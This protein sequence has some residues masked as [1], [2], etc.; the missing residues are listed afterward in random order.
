MAG[1]ADGGKERGV[2]L[3][4][5]TGRMGGRKVEVMRDGGA[6]TC[7]VRHSLVQDHEFTGRS[8]RLKTIDG[9]ELMAPEAALHVDTPYYKGHLTALALEKP[10]FDLVIGNIAGATNG[11]SESVCTQ[12]NA[13]DVDSC[14]ESVEEHEVMAQAADPKIGAAVSTRS[15]SATR[16]RVE[17][18]LAVISVQDLTD[19]RE[20]RELVGVDPTLANVRRRLL[21]GESTNLKNGATATY[22]KEHGLIYRV[23]VKDSGEERRQLV[24]PEK[25]REAVMKLAHSTTLSGHLGRGKTLTRVEAHFFW[26]GVGSDIARFVKSCDI[27]Q[28]TV[29]RGRIKPAPLQP[30]PIIDQPF[31]KMAVDI[32]GPIEPRASDGSRYILT[33][34][35][36]A[37]RWPEAVPLKNVETT[38]VAEAMVS[39][40]CRVGVPKQVLS[41]RGTQ[42]TSGMMDEVLRLL[43]CKGLHTTPYHPM[44]N[45]LCERFNGTLK[46]MLKRMT[47]EQPKEWPRFIA[48]LLFAYREAP[49]SSTRFSPFEMVYGR[50]VRGPLQMLR[51]LWDNQLPDPEVKATYQYVVD[52][53]GRLKETCELA[54]QELLK[55]REVQKAYYDKK[56]KLRKFCEGD[57]CLVLLPTATNKLLAQWKGPFDIQKKVND[58]NYIVRINGQPK[59]FHINMLKQYFEPRTVAACIETRVYDEEKTR[60]LALVKAQ[61]SAEAN[62]EQVAAAVVIAESEEGDGPVTP[63]SRRTETRHNVEYGAQLSTDEKA[64]LEALLSKYDEVFSDTPSVAKV[65]P[66]RIELTSE[67]PVRVKPYPIPL[68][69]VDAVKDEISEM[70][71]AGI[72][73]KSTSPYCS[74]MVVVKKKEGGI[75]ICGDYRRI[76]AVTRLDAEPMAD[77]QTIFAT[78]ANSRIFSK[79]DLTKGFFQVPLTEESKKVTAFS[80]PGGLYQYK[81]LPFGM[82]NSPAAFN[83]VMREVMRGVEGVA[84]FV[85]DVLIHSSSFKQH[86]ETLETVLK[87][88]R[89]YGLKIKPSKCMI[90]HQQVPFLGHV[91][92]DG[93]YACEEDKVAR[94]KDAPRPRTKKEVKSFLGL[95][96]YY[97]EYVPNFAV[98]AAPLH[99]LLKKQAPNM[100]HWTDLQE[101]AFLKL[102]SLLCKEPILQLPDFNK[103]FV[104]RTDASQE[105]V[106]AVLMQE[107]HGQMFPVSYYSRKLRAAERNYSTVEKELL[108]VVEGVKKYYF[109][110]YGDEFVLETDHLPLASLKTSKNANARLMRWAL[111][112]QQFAFSVR[113]IKGKTNIGADF[114]SRLPSHSEAPRIA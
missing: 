76:N 38:T 97:R 21:Q 66:H 39:V 98:V 6:N 26:P 19:S 73:E 82:T 81:A 62:E 10:L 43:S 40:F 63:A 12:T 60:C 70:E 72:I 9:T 52:L 109:Y 4:L 67:V 100:V 92:G 47:A 34:V 91:V 106:G 55:A 84:M 29:D 78:L 68:R 30:L 74:P 59:R 96:G 88:L 2:C 105:G 58:L 61:F 50:C 17:K 37:T 83:K 45:G 31:E 110:L 53:S 90:G 111:Y 5:G 46:K 8:H 28:K 24:V 54:K 15:S 35:D 99:E 87:R 51:E 7:V 114:L 42:F 79:I 11:L 16:K 71:A 102:K 23:V 41:D 95:A 1:G 56:A 20:V 69:L 36:F 13:A 108:A 57:K 65:K 103:E 27:C 85:D 112:L 104:L 22:V 32:V 75:R 48:P 49:Q 80:T 89:L 93:L 107:H 33:L 18:P 77:P 64:S 86:L 44:S 101:E 14:T 113:Y 94:V 3:N 25:Y